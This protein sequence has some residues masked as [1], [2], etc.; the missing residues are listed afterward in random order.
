MPEPNRNARNLLALLF[1]INLLNLIDRQV[2]YAVF[3]LI[4]KDLALSDTS[5]GLLG[6][7]FMICFMFSAP[8]FGIFGYRFSRTKMAAGALALWSLATLGAGLSSTYQSLL[9]MRSLVGAGEA[10]FA[11]VSPGLVAE[12]F[13]REVRSRVLSFFFLAGPLG[14]A[15]GYLLGGML[16]QRFG[17]HAA[18]LIAG[19]PGLVLFWPLWRFRD[20]MQ[21]K[22]GEAQEP[23]G[24]LMVAGAGTL[25]RNRTFVLITLAMAVM[26][27]A[28]GG[29]AQWLPTFFY[30]MHGLSVAKGS[31]IFGGITII[32]GIGGTL[33]GGYLGDHF[34]KGSSR[35]CLSV[36]AWGF[37]LSAPALACSLMTPVLSLSL[38]SLLI[39]EF[40]IFLYMGPL[41]KVIVN[42]TEPKLRTAAFALNLFFIRALGDASSPAV[43]GF[44]SDIFDLRKALLVTPFCL[45]LAAILCFV[46][47]RFNLREHDME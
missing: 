5:L 3:P 14:S 15:L 17:W 32:A 20:P 44:L 33:A 31:A 19:L 38:A 45:L 36:A 34:R 40:F 39:A 2:I 37:L 24:S 16:G 13:G 11:A 29:L 21:R 7:A 6:S 42:I 8:L 1:I 4:K 30:R 18:F 22:S 28:V 9:A 26:T 43:L 10:A 35:G 46:T 12:N 27:F 25:F 47:G 41:N 23:L